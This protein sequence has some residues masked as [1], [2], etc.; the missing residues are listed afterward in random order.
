MSNPIIILQLLVILIKFF[1][2]FIS[3]KIES[4]STDYYDEVLSYAAEF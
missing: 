2:S 3:K 1:I 4:V